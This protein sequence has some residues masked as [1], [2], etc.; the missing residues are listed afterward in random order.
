MKSFLNCLKKENEQDCLLKHLT[1]KLAPVLVGLKSSYLI[2][3][4]NCE[5]SGGRN[6]YDL[7]KEQ[8]EDIAERLGISFKEMKNTSKG[9]QVL[10]YNR[11]L[12]FD[13]LTQPE[14]FNFLKRFG[15]AYCKSLEDYLRLLKLRFFAAGLS[16]ASGEKSSFFPHEIGLFLGYPLKDVKGFIEKESPPSEGGC[17]QVFGEPGESLQIM[18]LH[19]KAEEVFLNL[20]ENQRDPLLFT[21]RLSRHFGRA[22]D[23]IVTQGV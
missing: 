16:A 11:Q 23:I 10:F 22:K 3:L 18:R 17:W 14:N 2:A 13:T 21:E 1:L 12:L 6:R 20:E 5:R 19:K 4:C 8:K 7:W 9:K 15:Y